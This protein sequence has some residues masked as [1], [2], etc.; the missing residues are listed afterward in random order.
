MYVKV[1]GAL[2]AVG[3]IEMNLILVRKWK[4][5]VQCVSALEMGGE[6]L[7]VPFFRTT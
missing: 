3:L 1:A 4:I 7:I 6:M 5:A 2:G